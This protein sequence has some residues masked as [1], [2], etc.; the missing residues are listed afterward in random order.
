MLIVPN[1]YLYAYSITRDFG[2]A[3]N[4]FHGICTLATCKPR[5]RTSA[6]IGD[7]V[8]GIGGSQLHA[9]KR[10]CI[11]LMKVT[12]KINFNDYWLDSRFS[13]K[14]PSR[15]GSHVQMLGDNIYHINADQ[16][17]VQEDSHHSNSDGSYNIENLERDTSSKF[18]LISNHFYYFGNAAVDI[19][20]QS[21]GYTKIRDYKKISISNSQGA[22][23]IIEKIHHDSKSKLNMV[24]SDPC[25]FSDFYKRVDQKSGVISL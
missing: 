4:P 8:L 12:E 22:R 11:L 9:V 23:G 13:L 1:S 3:P 10:K 24:I 17:W 15:N 7:W 5:I 14:K 25:Q 2:F 20:L 16:T 18:V 21:I 19:D 6:N